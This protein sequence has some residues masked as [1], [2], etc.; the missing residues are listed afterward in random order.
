[1][2]TFEACWDGY[3]Q[4]GMKKKGKRTVPNCVPEKKDEEENDYKRIKYNNYGANFINIYLPKSCK[5]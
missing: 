3:T 5:I 2:K 4:K 1:M